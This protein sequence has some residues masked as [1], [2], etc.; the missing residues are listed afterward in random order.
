M[1]IQE[2]YVIQTRLV[3][4]LGIAVYSIVVSLVLY[5]IVILCDI[6][7][8]KLCYMNVKWTTQSINDC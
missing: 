8:N 4:I 1:N 6:V 2:K 5:G 3:V 7:N